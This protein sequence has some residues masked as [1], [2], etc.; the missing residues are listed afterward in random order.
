MLF[1]FPV[2]EK[3][4]KILPAITHVDGTARV[5]CVEKS[6]EPQYW[7]LLD[8]FEKIKKI[9]IVLNTSFNVMCEPIVFT[10]DQA[11]RCFYGS[12]IDMLVIGD[13]IIE[14]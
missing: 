6:I 14:K 12:G 4:K 2:R 9:P 5:Q 11:I 13:Y 3:Y 7:K 10:P 8:E 1:T